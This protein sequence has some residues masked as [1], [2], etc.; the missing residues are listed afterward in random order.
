MTTTLTTNRL[1]AGELIEVRSKEEIL[2]TLDENGCLEGLPF[3][4]EML[5]FCGRRMRVFKRAHKTCDT[6]DNTGGRWVANAV[7]LEGSRCDGCVHGGCQAECLIFWKEAWLKRVTESLLAGNG[8]GGMPQSEKEAASKGAGYSKCDLTTCIR[9]KSA[10]GASEPVYVCQAT[11]MTRA[12]SPIKPWDWRQYWE[13]YASGNVS[14]KFMAGVWFYANYTAIINFAARL[15]LR[16]A[17]IGVYNVV[18]KARSRLPHPRA[19][20]KIAMGARTPVVELN[21]QPGELV[22]VKSF[23]EILETIDWDYYN[24]GL[25]WDAEMAPYCGGVFR[26]RK[27]V[28]YII[29]EKTGKMIHLKTEPIMLE[30]AVCQSKYSNCRYFCP[31][32]I[33][34]YWREIWLERV[35]ETAHGRQG[36]QV[37]RAAEELTTR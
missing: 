32:A 34:S 4:P 30:G 26:V 20:G 14:L 15:R 36:T 23:E 3:M 37:D 11:E 21:L 10:D 31:R 33:Y 2:A 7:H 35:D 8:I 12:S 6:I 19:R 22:R 5:E 9:R 13:D 24:R 29:N 17:L 27:R 25:R 1:K 18:Q 28:K 16:R